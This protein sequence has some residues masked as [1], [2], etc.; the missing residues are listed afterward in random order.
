MSVEKE[1]VRIYTFF[2]FMFFEDV[3]H[4]NSASLI[5]SV[6]P[7]LMISNMNRTYFAH[8]CWVTCSLFSFLGLVRFS[9]FLVQVCTVFRIQMFKFCR[10]WILDSSIYL[11]TLMKCTRQYRDVKLVLPR[12][13]KFQSHFDKAVF[14]LARYSFYKE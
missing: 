10:I 12:A 6:K 2:S 3:M 8:K 9:G 13:N 1:K 14:S 5:A 11:P 4:Q 7:N